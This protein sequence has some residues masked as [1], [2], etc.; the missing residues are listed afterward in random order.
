MW[1][2]TNQREYIEKCVLKCL[3]LAFLIKYIFGSKKWRWEILIK[4]VFGSQS[5]KGDY[6]INLHFYPN[7][8]FKHYSIEEKY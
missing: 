6:K 5:K 1:I 2:L 8:I 3:L 7:I 4:N